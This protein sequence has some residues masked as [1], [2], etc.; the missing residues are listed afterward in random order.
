MVSRR[1]VGGLTRGCRRTQGL[2]V[3]PRSTRAA[4]TASFNRLRG[5]APLSR[6]LFYRACDSAR[7]NPRTR[8]M[9]ARTWHG[10]VPAEKAGAYHDYLLETGVPD[11]QTT[12][13]NCGGSVNE[14]GDTGSPRG[15][16]A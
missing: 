12:P 3:L 8:L 11:Y 1:P 9:I 4:Y 14:G 5:P 2:T 13:G 15:G 6:N 7:P 16:P 10:A